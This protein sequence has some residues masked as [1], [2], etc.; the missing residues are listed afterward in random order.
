MKKD[1]KILLLSISFCLV[2][3]M[4]DAYLVELLFTANVLPAYIAEKE[5]IHHLYFRSFVA[6]TFL[7]F[8]MTVSKM[9]QKCECAESELLSQL[10]FE[11]I[12]AEISSNFIG[13][14][15]YHID[16]GIRLSLKKIAEFSDADR[17]YLILFSNYRGENDTI[18]KWNA[19]HVDDTNIH[20]VSA[21]HF[22]WWME[23]LQNPEIVHISDVS[24]LPSE[25]SE[26]KDALQKAGITSVLSIP[27]QSNG[28]LLGFMG[29]DSFSKKKVWSANYIKLM[30]VVG[31]I[32]V[33]SIERKKAEESVLKHKE[34]LARAQEISHTGSWEID[35]RTKKHFWSEE[36]YRIMGFL[37]D[38]IPINKEIYPSLIHPNDRSL[39]HSC[40]D[41]ALS[42]PGYKFDVKTRVIKKN[43]S[44]CILHSLGEVTW[45]SEGRQVLFQGTTQDITDLSL[46]EEDLQRKNRNLLI[47]QS[48]ALIA[49][50]SLEMQD[51]LDDILMEILSYAGCNSGIVCLF[52]S[53][54][55]NFRIC[56]SNGIKDELK[57]EINCINF[58]DPLFRI[59]PDIKNTWDTDELTNISGS[60]KKI[61]MNENVG[62]LVFIPVISR[63]DLVGIVLLFPGHGTNI[64]NT[65]LDI[66][67]NVGH[68]VGIAVE[69]IRLVDETRKAYEELKSLDRMKDEFVAN[70]THELKTPLI[71]IKGY[72]EAIYD[73]L[74]G[75]LDEKQRQ[76]MK[77]VVSN[78]ERLEQLI[79]SL[80]NMNSLYFEKYHVLSPIHLKDVLDN[81]ISTL[82]TRIEDKKIQLNTDYSF[83]MNLVYGNCEFLKYLF[84]YLLDNAIKFSSRG[85]VV[86]VSINEDDTSIYVDI[87]DHG[88]G[89]PK[90]CMDRIFDRFYQVDGSA[91][92]IHGGNGLGLYLAKNIV[93]L[94][95]GTIEVESEEGVGTV[96]HVSIPL[97][98]SDIHD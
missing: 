57:N 5:F 85:S 48:T 67:G 51:F 95:S 35:L 40:V 63:E 80:L 96:V 66:L 30:R 61:V 17:S 43:G 73:G 50:S 19:E 64:S 92:R 1:V 75:E 52:S 4:A 82:S 23:K 6:I 42:I 72:S 41:K 28:R 91:T 3:L 87:S 89:I 76:C 97:Y 90:I 22:P 2:F 53:H 44:A 68:Q 49:A 77:I 9:A 79:E 10:K 16:E 21:R 45:D 33:D 55:K 81:A 31:D 58:D 86:S 14:K 46:V 78:S 32:F 36:M 74:L 69:N 18:Y 94:H 8:G 12:V 60:L 24:K 47:L 54:D 27:L 93:E 71:S 26:E 20:Y 29:F 88:T 98:N 65:D 13:K 38:E 83:D 11:N 34:R 25:A 59:V 37:P 15:S 84:V 70:I 39:F 62:R 56:S 7:L